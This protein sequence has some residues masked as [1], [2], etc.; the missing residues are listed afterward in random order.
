MSC[1]AQVRAKLVAEG[2]LGPATNW[3]RLETRAERVA[4]G[5]SPL[6]DKEKPEN[7]SDAP[8]I[9]WFLANP[10]ASG[11]ACARVLG[12]DRGRAAR[13]RQRLFRDGRIGKS[14][15]IEGERPRS[16]RAQTIGLFIEV[17]GP[18]WRKQTK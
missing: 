4:I 16:V 2:K 18:L 15:R 12:I 11:R 14:T 3:P 5:L 8:V 10:T 1:C 9:A 13:I 6:P 7:L 17:F